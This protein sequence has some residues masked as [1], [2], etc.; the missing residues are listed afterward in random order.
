MLL[1]VNA[2]YAGVK[3]VASKLEYLDG[4]IERAMADMQ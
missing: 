4:K 3:F 1:L 2:L